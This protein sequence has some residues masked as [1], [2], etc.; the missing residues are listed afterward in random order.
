MTRPTRT[1]VMLLEGFHIVALVTG[2][3]LALL[4]I[5][6]VLH[7][8]EEVFVQPEER[9]AAMVALVASAREP[10]EVEDAVTRLL[11]PVVPPQA[12]V[13]VGGRR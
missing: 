8:L 2:A 6:M 4:G 11:E 9:A 5:V 10:D 13:P 12:R 1:V 7:V 3:P